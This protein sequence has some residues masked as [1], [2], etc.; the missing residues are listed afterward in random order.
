MIGLNRYARRKLRTMLKTG[1][2]LHRGYR[3]EIRVDTE[4]NLIFVF[5]KYKNKKYVLLR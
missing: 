2:N 4:K 5:D 1:K 3:Y